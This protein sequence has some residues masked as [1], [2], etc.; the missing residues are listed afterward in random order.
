[1]ITSSLRR[2]LHNQGGSTAIEYALI[3][4]LL[5]TIIVGTVLVLGTKLEAAYQSV[6]DLF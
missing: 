2:F 6:V 4:A 1:M 5:S 3:A